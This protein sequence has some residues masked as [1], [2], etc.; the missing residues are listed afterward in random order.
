VVSYAD[1]QWDVLGTMLIRELSSSG[2]VPELLSSSCLSPVLPSLWRTQGRLPQASQ[3]HQ[4]HLLSSS[5][6]TW[7]GF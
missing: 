2:R 4:F 5:E 6:L 1:F 3:A 7:Y